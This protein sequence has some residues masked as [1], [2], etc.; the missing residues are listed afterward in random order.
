MRLSYKPMTFKEYRA[1]VLL[2]RKKNL[3][4]RYDQIFW[5]V[6]SIAI[7]VAFAICHARVG[8]EKVDGYLNTAFYYSVCLAVGLP[9]L[10][11]LN[12]VLGFRAIRKNQ[13]EPVS[14]IT[15]IDE[16][17]ITDIS[18]GTCELTYEWKS[19]T[20]IGQ[21]EKITVICT[22]GHHFLYFPT[23]AFSPEQRIEFNKIASG[24]NVRRWSC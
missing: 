4:L 16:N 18:P 20:G 12:I 13:K 24:Y 9:L 17:R 15:E 8:Y 7:L 3:F 21:N 11:N 10:R 22:T 14:N 19:V 2:F 1:A 6:L 23:F 5:I